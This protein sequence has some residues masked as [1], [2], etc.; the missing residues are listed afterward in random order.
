MKNFIETNNKDNVK[1]LNENADELRYIK[2]E[3]QK[4]RE[5]LH[6]RLI[7]LEDTEKTK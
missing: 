1:G 2:D 4:D 3:I 5:Y 7:Q 6:S